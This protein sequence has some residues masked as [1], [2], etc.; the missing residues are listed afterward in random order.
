M[1]KMMERLLQMIVAAALAAGVGWGSYL[2]AE[3]NKI[4]DRATE[5]Q[6]EIVR[7][8]TQ[9][10]YIVKV[11]DRIENR[12]DALNPQVKIYVPQKGK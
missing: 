9:Y 7:N 6:A 8:K 4:K 12:V 2:T 11:L 10:E 1:S 3:T 5:Q